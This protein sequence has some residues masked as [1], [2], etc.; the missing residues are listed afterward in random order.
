MRVVLDS[1]PAKLET[2]PGEPGAVQGR[3]RPVRA[4]LLEATEVKTW[5]EFGSIW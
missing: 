2:A 3:I 1:V 5:P 4:Y